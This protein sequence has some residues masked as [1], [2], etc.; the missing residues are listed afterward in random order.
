VNDVVRSARAL[1]W[2]RWRLFVNALKGTRRRD[3]LERLS[4]A[5]S[6]IMPIILGLMRSRVPGLLRLSLI[7]GWSVGQRVQATGDP[8]P[9][10][11]LGAMQPH[12][13]RAGDPHGAR[14]STNLVRLA[15]L[16]CRQVL[17]RPGHAS[18]LSDPRVAMVP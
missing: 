16:P 10:G 5:G 17:P 15:L 9:C 11:S 7:G 1:G 12:P 18:G 3:T 2:L 13:L 14:P 6:V 4:R 8:D